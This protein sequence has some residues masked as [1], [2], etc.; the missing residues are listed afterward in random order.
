V[1]AEHRICLSIS[2]RSPIPAIVGQKDSEALHCFFSR[3]D[4]L[5][6]EDIPEEIMTCDILCRLIL[7][8]RR[9][10]EAKRLKELEEENRRL[11]HA[12]AD[13]TLDKQILKEALDWPAP[14]FGARA[15][16]SLT[17][18]TSE[19]NGGSRHLQQLRGFQCHLRVGL[20]INI[21]PANRLIRI[22]PLC[23]W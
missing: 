3:D 13:L 7:Q 12:V 6:A 23:Q 20:P 2:A 15:Y 9:P 14:I 1:N 19:D 4:T 22:L 16:E 5:H 8:P 17:S 18:S 10:A 11:K 21:E